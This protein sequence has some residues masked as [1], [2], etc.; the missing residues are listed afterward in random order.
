MGAT[1]Y[2]A[3]ISEGI[4]RAK[5][6]LRDAVGVAVETR[7]AQQTQCKIPNKAAAGSCSRS[8]FLDI[9]SPMAEH[10]YAC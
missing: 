3:Y 1:T 9:G 5:L 10:S 8:R 2:V 7:V 6:W 4:N